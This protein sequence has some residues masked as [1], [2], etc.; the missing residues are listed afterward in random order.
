MRR[1][2]FMQKTAA[3]SLLSGAG[4]GTVTSANNA[5][6]AL[7]KTSGG[8][9]LVTIAASHEP[10]LRN[11]A[12]LDAELSYTQVRDIVWLALDRDTSERS[13]LKIVKKDSWVVIKTNIVR[14]VWLSPEGYYGRPGLAPDF[15]RDEDG[16]ALV[17]DLRVVKAIVE[18]LTGKIAPRR[19][20]IAEGPA[21]WY[22]SKGKIKPGN[23]I[24]GWHYEF[25]GF[26]NLSYVK[27]VEQLNG[28][29][30]SVVDIVDLN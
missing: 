9:P 13:L 15:E 27:I 24:D 22:N 10:E 4:V 6:A 18:Y 14:V 2:E 20:T 17:T 21:E 16:L 25:K 30:K 28:K 1:R 29:N 3:G 23:Y 19:I 26:D 12:P 11:P 8:K 7:S 5:S